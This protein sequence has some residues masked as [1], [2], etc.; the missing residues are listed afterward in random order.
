MAQAVREK[1]ELDAK[2]RLSLFQSRS[3]LQRATVKLKAKRSECNSKATHARN[4]Y[5]LML[6]AANAHQQ[7]Y[8]NTDLMDCIK[9][10]DGRIYEQVKDYLVS[11]CQTE[12]ESYQAVHN[13]FN[14]L[15]NSSNGVSLQTHW[16][17]S[18]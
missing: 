13:T 1:A 3:S 8:Y 12:L 14:Q 17:T 10:L 9:V 16:T 18:T 2:S 5:I 15:L 4:D 7:R 6:A 11:L